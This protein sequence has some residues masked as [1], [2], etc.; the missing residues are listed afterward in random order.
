MNGEVPSWEAVA[1]THG[2]FLYNVA[3]RLTGKDDDA[4]DLVQEA[5]LRVRKGLETYQPGSM[6]AWLSRIVTNV[7]LDEVRRKRRRPVEVMP[8]DP[9]RLLPSAPGADEATESLSDD[10]QAAL[11]RL[12]EEFRTAVVLCDVV[13]LSYE[14]IADAISIPVGT[15]RS[16]I[17]RGRRLL[18][19]ALQ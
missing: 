11:R 5:L 6:E 9:E 15:V 16:R 3:Y 4:Y 1:R 2:R 19:A 10:V 13:G 14:E 12:P 8:E 18:R 17:H 7:F